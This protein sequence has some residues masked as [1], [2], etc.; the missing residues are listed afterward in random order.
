MATVKISELQTVQEITGDEQIPVEYGG[1]NYKITPRQIAPYVDIKNLQ[2]FDSITGAEKVI[3]VKDGKAQGLV[4]LTQI[5]QVVL[6]GYTYEDLSMDKFPDLIGGISDNGT[7]TTSM[8]QRQE[9][10]V[11]K[12][13]VIAITLNNIIDSGSFVA[14]SQFAFTTQSLVDL[15]NGDNIP[16]ADGSGKYDINKLESMVL[17]VPENAR[18]L[19]INSYDTSN[20]YAYKCDWSIQIGELLEDKV[21][22]LSARVNALEQIPMATSLDSVSREEFDAL[23]NEI[24]KIRLNTK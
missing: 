16:Y 14:Y 24:E 10:P 9:I 7:F 12:G 17:E 6:P 15:V 1:K 4:T 22:E 11:K 23:R 5:R 3:V 19:V 18:Y 20:R 13:Q 8:I 2:T 21:E